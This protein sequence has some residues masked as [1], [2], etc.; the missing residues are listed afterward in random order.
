MC[1]SLDF[2]FNIKTPCSRFAGNY[3][4]HVYREVQLLLHKCLH[5]SIWRSIADQSYTESQYSSKICLVHNF[6]S[7]IILPVYYLYQVKIPG[8]YR[9]SLISTTTTETSHVVGQPNEI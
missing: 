9:K 7:D 8:Y 3:W 6:L 1:K 4:K 2:I 5:S